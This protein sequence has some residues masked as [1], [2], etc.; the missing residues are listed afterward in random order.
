MI[1]YCVGSD[2]MEACPLTA[3]RFWEAYNIREDTAL[4]GNHQIPVSLRR[5]INGKGIRE[6]W[7]SPFGGKSRLQFAALI[8]LLFVESLLRSLVRIYVSRLVTLEN[9]PH[10][11]LNSSE[12]EKSSACKNAFLW[13]SLVRRA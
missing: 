2:L 11:L 12:S 5:P 13:K 1:A 8:G 3:V 7:A 9:R 4:P 6:I 10:L